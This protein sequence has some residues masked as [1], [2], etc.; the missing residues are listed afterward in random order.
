MNSLTKLKQMRIPDF[1]SIVVASGVAIIA[2]GCATSNLAV[3]SSPITL[4]GDLP[5]KNA[6]LTEAQL[7]TWKG[8]DLINDTIPGMSVDKAYNEIIKNQKGEKVIVAILDSGVDIEHEDLNSKIWVNDDEIPNNGIDD[9]NNG[10]VD[11][12]HGWNFLGDMVGANLNLTRILKDL[13]PKYDGISAKDISAENQEEYELYKRANAE[14]EE[15]YGEALQNKQRYEMLLNRI[16]NAKSTLAEQLG[17]EDFSKEELAE[18]TTDDTTLQGQKRFLLAIMSN[19]GEDFDKVKTQLNDAIEYFGHQLEYHYNLSFNGRE[20]V[21]DN[22]D[23]LKDTEYGNN[24]VDGPTEEE[25]HAMHGTHVAGII[26]AERNNEIGVNGVA[27]NVELM[28]LRAVPDGDEFD[29]DIALAIRYAVDNGA[30]IINGSFGKYYSSHPKW[31]VEAIKYAAKNDVL[32][33]RAAGNDA[34]DL[35]EKRVYPNDQWPEHTEE[36]SNNF[37][38]VGALNY[39]YGEGI[40]AGF[41]NYGTRTVDVFAPGVKIYSSI[42][43]DEYKFLQGTSMASPAVAGVAAVIRSYYPKLSASQVKQIIMDSGIAIDIPVVVP[44][45]REERTATENIKDFSTLSTSGKIVNL[46]NAL[47]LADKIAK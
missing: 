40:V 14:Y 47:I 31:V 2:A 12:V 38:T 15:K 36:I 30:K 29:K 7:K 27:E 28:V 37:L 20:V 8:D 26:G 22:P 39:E 44:T 43:H 23:D 35:N 1:K 5:T 3:S 34:Q 17:K 41:S 6:P 18:F 19:V 11:D 46:Y 33:V 4:S 25:A 42:P 10:Y 9:D 21:G 32:I 45:P 24:D 16:N 13:K